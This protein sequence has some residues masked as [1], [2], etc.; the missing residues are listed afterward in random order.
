MSATPFHRVSPTKIKCLLTSGSEYNWDPLTFR[1]TATIGII[2][3]I[4]AILAVWQG[5]LNAG[6]GRIKANRRAIGDFSKHT[7]HEFSWR[8]F[9]F[10]TMARTPYISI[11]SLHNGGINWHGASWAIHE[12]K[13]RDI[14][15][16]HA[17]KSAF[18]F[19]SKYAK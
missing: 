7:T 19:F 12:K 18:A 3:A 4:L 16:E 5:L 11:P 17:R 10:R 13:S 8:E 2:A 6:V 14:R 15:N 9:R 1:F